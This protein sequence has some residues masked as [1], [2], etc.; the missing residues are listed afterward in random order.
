[1]STS[2]WPLFDLR[3]RSADLELRP[4][5]EADLAAVSE[6]LPDD[7]DLNPAA[8]R[9]AGVDDRMSRRI[10]IHQDYW[11]A[12]GT[13]CPQAWRLNF[14]VFAHGELVGAQEVEGNDFP[15]LRTVDSA[16]FLAVAARG[17]GYGKLMRC[18][19]LTL[20]FDFLKAEAAISSA[21]HD[22]YASLGVSQALGYQPNGQS[23]LARGDAVDVLNHFRLTRDA[24]SRK[25]DKPPVEISGFEACPHLF[26]I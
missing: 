14:L 5:T 17:R 13:W 10:T 6:L 20:A 2:A 1:M 26:G 9:Y 4:M 3:L 25:L 21:F 7:V 22:N 24:W 12:M 18:I 11:K 16:S 8:T 23:L 19:A 15:T